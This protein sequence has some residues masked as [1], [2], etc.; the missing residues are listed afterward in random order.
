MKGSEMCLR[1]PHCPEWETMYIRQIAA[2][3]PVSY[4]PCCNQRPFVT[5]EGPKAHPSIRGPPAIRM[6]RG[7]AIMYTH[8]TLSQHT[9]F[10]ARTSLMAP[11]EPRATSSTNITRS[12][13]CCVV[14]YN[15]GVKDEVG[16]G[17]VGVEGKR[18]KKRTDGP[19]RPPAPPSAR[20]AA[21]GR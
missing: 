17:G 2:E 9:F 10:W 19:W 18:N 6:E 8:N 13:T 21:G 16:K 20:S 7:G 15:P 5:E 1:P 3:G 14:L 11:S 12:A 4:P